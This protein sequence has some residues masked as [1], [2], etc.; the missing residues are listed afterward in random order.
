[1]PFILPND[2]VK[3]WLDKNVDDSDFLIDMIKPYPSDKLSMRGKWPPDKT[4]PGEPTQMN[5]FWS[6]YFIRDYP[7]KEKRHE[8][9][10][11][12]VTASYIGHRFRN[13]IEIF[14]C[15]ETKQKIS[16]HPKCPFY[17]FA[18]T[19]ICEIDMVWYYVAENS[20]LF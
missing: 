19:G 3:V 6:M 10:F 20:K 14:E 13:E 11:Q 7:Q 12:V 4:D 18:F 17:E 8:K 15:E 5:L 1:M 9:E 16:A 2:R